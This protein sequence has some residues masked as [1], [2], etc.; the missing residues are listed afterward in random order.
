[1]SNFLVNKHGLNVNA[2]QHVN[3]P[4]M[5]HESI[6]VPSTS[7]PSWGG[8]FVIDFRERNCI[9][10][11]ITLQFNVS[12]LTGYTGSNATSPR[13]TPAFFW[14]TRIELVQNNNVIDTIYPSQQFISNQLFNADEQRALINLSCGAYKNTTQRATLATAANAYYVDLF[15]YFQ[16]GHLPI[17]SQQNDL[18]IRVYM[19]TLANNAVTGTATLSTGPTSVLNSCNLIAK[20]SRLHSQDVAQRIREISSRPQHFKFNETRFGTFAVNAGV[21]STSIVLTPLTGHC[22]YLFFTVRPTA[23]LT[24]E[25]AYNYT[26]ISSY[27]LLD[28]TSTNIVGGQFIP[29]TLALLY[30]GRSWSK[31]SYLGETALSTNNNGANVY[32]WSFSADASETATTGVDLNTYKFTGNEQL[33]IIFVG[34]LAAGVTVEV[35]AQIASAIEVSHHGVKKLSIH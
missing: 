4:H 32:I 8:Y 30:L 1:M 7:A 2:S 29:N 17:L 13:Y 22:N 31:S 33:Q 11:D 26:A 20:V 3:L 25:G 16:Q 34:S 6:I 35:F 15:N 23:S 18:Q 28:G 10:H 5:K 9:L 27:A 12:A 24:G 14:F 19:D 21:A